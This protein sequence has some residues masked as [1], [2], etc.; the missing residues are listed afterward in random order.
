M[1]AKK[2]DSDAKD[3][4][5]RMEALWRFPGIATV[6]RSIV[7]CLEMNHSIVRSVVLINTILVFKAGVGLPAGMQMNV[8][9]DSLRF[10]HLAVIF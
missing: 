5:A 8:R 4:F 6:I 1:K 2:P 10:D 3:S 7:S 9:C